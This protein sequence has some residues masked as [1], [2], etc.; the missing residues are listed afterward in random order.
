MSRILVL[1]TETTGLSAAMGHRLTEIA[2]VEIQHR[3]LTGN[4]W[5]SYLNPERELDE[6]AARIT[7]LSWQ[8]LEGHPKFSEIVSDFIQ[9][10]D[11]AILVIHNASFDLEFL[12]SELK[13][14][15]VQYNLAEQHEIEDTLRLARKLH[16]G[17][18]NNLDALAK[19]YQ[20][21]NTMR[22]QHGALL[23]AT[24][25]AKIYLQMTYGQTNLQFT[26]E[27]TNVTAANM[28]TKSEAINQQAPLKIAKVSAA[29]QAAHQAFL[30]DIQKT[31]N[32]CLWSSLNKT[33][34]IPSETD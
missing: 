6:G 34:E 13:L 33:M 3:R 17:Q 16:P 23:D 32:H 27:T 26:E 20:I 4:T 22:A 7:G 11:G 28:L 8:F 15:G 25:L 19:R 21:T 29:D 5:Q 30:V 24:L 1:D 9:Y 14:A 12:H 10:I 2:M 18:K 31:S